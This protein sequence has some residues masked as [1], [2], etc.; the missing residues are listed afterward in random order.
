MFTVPENFKLFQLWCELMCIGNKK[1]KIRGS[2]NPTSCTALVCYVTWYCSEASSCVSVVWH[3]ETHSFKPTGY[4]LSFWCNLNIV[5]H[6]RRCYCVCCGMH[7][8]L[9][10]TAIRDK[11]CIHYVHE[12]LRRW[13]EWIPGLC[14]G[15]G[16]LN[17]LCFVYVLQLLL[18]LLIISHCCELILELKSF[19]FILL[20]RLMLENWCSFVTKASS[21]T[22]QRAGEID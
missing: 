8:F 3:H 11:S 22:S 2:D 12:M 17:V 13:D 21:L 14:E 20:T 10:A 1:L 5:F 15:W 9:S 19:L 16:N 18:M 4:K 6:P 7:A